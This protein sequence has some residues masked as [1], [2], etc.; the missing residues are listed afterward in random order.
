MCLILFAWRVHPRYRLVLAANRDEFH[1]RRSAAAA[2]WED[3]RDLLG[4]RDLESM[5]TWLG[6]TRAGRIA[7]V[8]NV[9]DG[10]AAPPAHAPS[11]G[12]LASDFLRGEATPEEY[13]AALSREG[14]AYHG[15]NLL[16]ADQDALWW[17]SNRGNGA[18]RLEP[19]VYGVANDLLD[20]PWPK[21]TAGKN[22]LERVLRTGPSLASLLALL[23]DT[24]VYADDEL[25]DTG[26]GLERERMLAP[27]RIVAPVYGTRCSS[28]VLVEADGH[29]QFAERSYD[30]DG[31]ER[32]TF[33]YA[34][35]RSA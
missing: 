6:V 34:F 11:R 28:A 27:I 25:P 3:R 4:G 1:A 12:R 7:A 30:P 18:R 2:F 31:A 33:Y 5:G 20:T 19:G 26:V 35:E 17:T 9:R 15:F 23:D 29:T 8:T 10:R 32:D 16:V 13:A 21:V 24:H 14:R 22:A